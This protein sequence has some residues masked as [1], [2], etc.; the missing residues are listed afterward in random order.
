M[1]ATQHNMLEETVRDLEIKGRSLSLLVLV[2]FYYAV[3]LPFVP[4]TARKCLVRIWVVMDLTNHNVFIVF[5][6]VFASTSSKR[7]AFYTSI[8]HSLHRRN[9]KWGNIQL[10]GTIKL[11]TTFKALIHRIKNATPQTHQ[12]IA[13]RND[14]QQMLWCIRYHAQA[15]R[16]VHEIETWSETQTVSANPQM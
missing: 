7:Y 14:L 6:H 8:S 13:T 9:K 4:S 3:P 16:H 15:S 5:C 12:H 2:R 10:V 1:T 11:N